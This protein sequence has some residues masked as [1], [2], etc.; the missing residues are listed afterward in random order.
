MTT[1]GIRRRGFLKGACSAVALGNAAA[2]LGA[3]L[4]SFPAQAATTTYQAEIARIYR[5]VLEALHSGFSG[6]AYVNTFQEVGSYVEWLVTVPR[7][8]AATLVIRFANGSNLNRPMEVRVN[9]A[10]VD[11]AL[12]F[13]P[14]GNWSLWATRSLTAALHAGTNIVRFTSTTASGGPNIDLLDVNDGTDWG[15]AMVDST[16]A[17]SPDPTA[18]G[19]WTYYRAFYLLGQ[20][21]V[22]QRTRDSRYLDYIRGWIDR[23]VDDNGNID[24]IINDLNKILPGNLLLILHRETGLGKY[25]LATD[26]VRLV[27]ETYPRTSDG[28]FWHAADLE[29]QLWLDGTY[30]ALPFLARY[31]QAYGDRAYAYNEVANQLLIYARHL[32]HESNGL[33]YHG[34]DEQGDSS[35]ANPVTHRSA[36][37]WGRSIGWYGMALVDVLDILPANHAQRPQLIALVQGLVAAFARF[38]DPATGRW[39]QVVD[40]GFLAGNWLETSCS[41]M[42]TYIISKAIERGYVPESTYAATGRKGFQGVLTQVSFGTNGRTI[43]ENICVGTNIG[44]LDYYLARPRNTNEIHGLGAFLI[45]YE[46]TL[47]QNWR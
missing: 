21:R 42:Y 20:Y 4:L 10:V 2:F 1:N 12:S 14:T 17:R 32:K 15:M 18:F 39:Y 5:G 35:W 38:Q 27:F 25:R 44:D 34:Y 9:G 40:K 26:K 30:M 43:L 22:Y 24:S 33:L 8:V 16:I 28:G 19:S 29:G 23:H 46:Q 41:C 7:E 13:A 11:P 36:E 31:G 47:A 37:F 45:M 3:P 6:I